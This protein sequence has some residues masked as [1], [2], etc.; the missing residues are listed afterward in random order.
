MQLTLVFGVNS[1]TFVRH[2]LTPIM[3]V[4]SLYPDIS[5]RW[6]FWAAIIAGIP[7]AAYITGTVFAPFSYSSWLIFH[8]TLVIT[9]FIGSFLV[10]HKY[11]ISKNTFRKLLVALI[12]YFSIIMIL[13][14]GS[15]MLTTG[16]FSDRMKWIPFFFRDYE[17]HAFPSVY[18]YLNHATNF[19]GLLVLQIFSF[20]INS[21]FYFIAGTLGYFI[22]LPHFSKLN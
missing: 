10:G 9:S 5:L 12:L 3:N 13:Y 16:L 11:Q 17:Y 7:L 20:L 1:R 6:A 14:L 22:N 4:K 15:Y 8:N 21:I 18:D 19:K 2:L